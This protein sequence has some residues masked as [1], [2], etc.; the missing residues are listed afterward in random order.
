VRAVLGDEP[1]ELVD[2]PEGMAMDPG[3]FFLL[4]SFLLDM[5][6]AGGGRDGR[7][8]KGARVVYEKDVHAVFVACPSGMSFPYV[9][10]CPRVLDALHRN[11]APF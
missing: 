5:A 9:I 6:G 7:E 11:P 3:P 4:P 8:G 10:E 1:A 2:L